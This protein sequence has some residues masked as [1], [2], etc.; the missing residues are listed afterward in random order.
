MTNRVITVWYRCGAC[1]GAKRG[2][3][4]PAAAGAHR[5]CAAALGVS[6]L[7]TALRPAR[8]AA[9]AVPGVGALRPGD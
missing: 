1:R 7:P 4:Q 3:L 9:R 8:Q 5:C 2:K 6:A